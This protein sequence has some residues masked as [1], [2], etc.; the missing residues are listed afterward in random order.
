MWA[1]MKR[2]RWLAVGLSA[3]VAL[4]GGV[5]LNGQTTLPAGETLLARE[6]ASVFRVELIAGPEREASA[7]AVEVTGPGFSQGWRISTANLAG[8]AAAI[9]WGA[10]T[11]RVVRKGDVGLIRFF[12][13]KISSADETGLAR[14]TV[15]VRKSGRTEESFSFG[16]AYSVG[17]EWQEVLA[18]FSFGRDF[19]AGEAT[20]ALR[21]GLKAQV[22]EI[23]GVEVI[24]Y[25]QTQTMAKLP[26]IHQTYR[27]R[28]PEAA[29]RREA[30]ARIERI[31]R[32]D[33]SVRVIDAAGRP[34]PDAEVRV[35]QRRPAFHFGSAVQFRRFFSDAPD[36]IRYREKV[37]ELFTSASS[38]NELKWD[39]WVGDRGVE[40]TQA[41]AL[42]GLHWLRVNGFHARGHV[43]VWPGWRHLPKFLGELRDRDKQAEIP[44][45]TLDHIHEITTKT[46]GLIDEWDVINEPFN[47][48]DL[49]TLFGPE[50]MADW[51]KAARAGAP[52]ARLFLNDFGNHDRVSQAVHVAHFQ[53]TIR[54]LRGWGA[55][56][57]GL[58]LQAHFGTKPEAPEDVLR[59]LDLYWD[60]FKLPI[61]FTEFDV[62]TTDEELQADFTRDFFILAFSHPAVDGVQMWGFW[63]GAHWR[64]SAAMLRADWSEK[65]NAKV[66][67]ELVLEKWR[68]RLEA[69]TDAQGGYA[70]RGY[71]GEYEVEVVSGG[72]RVK[73][74]FTLSAGEVAP[75]VVVALKGSTASGRH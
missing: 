50:I 33:F 42:A 6:G 21:F 38:Q 46:N 68:T 73:E 25:G 5:A 16:E 40:H 47:N 74:G 23:G 66:Y 54:Q 12:A 56:L 44:G 49:M 13:R 70:A 1:R 43:L 67:R 51:F 19:A 28:E 35:T 15:L 4:Q 52:D 45:R 57:G 18:P 17:A 63:E 7:Q 65:P 60:E 61:R 3:W 48:R 20:V 64:P 71:F 31:R 53:E 41:I 59:T 62:W 11:A 75:V 8:P 24:Y 9:E 34:V 2:Y 37:R 14:L 26:R 29:W 55:P 58:G 69:R 36:D 72:E 30:L 32:G 10:A 22:I 39:T 27:G